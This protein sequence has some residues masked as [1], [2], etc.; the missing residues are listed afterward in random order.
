MITDAQ[1]SGWLT[2]ARSL[3]HDFPADES[4]IAAC[5]IHGDR[6]ARVKTTGTRQAGMGWRDAI[7]GSAA[8]A[9]LNLID[10]PITVT[11]EGADTERWVFRCTNAASNLWELIREHRGLVWSGTY[12]PYVSGTPVDVAPINPR[13]RDETARTARRT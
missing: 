9:T 5:L 1:I 8:T 11:N 4:I 13:T 2:L 3:S 7:Y 6:R 10:Y 12:A